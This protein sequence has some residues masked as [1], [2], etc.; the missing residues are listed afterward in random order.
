MVQLCWRWKQ[1]KNQG[2]SEGSRLGIEF[3]AVNIQMLTRGRLCHVFPRLAVSLTA[4]LQERQVCNTPQYKADLKT[5]K[6]FVRQY[7]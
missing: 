6:S 7:V 1:N 5:F 3:L 4:S 2:Q